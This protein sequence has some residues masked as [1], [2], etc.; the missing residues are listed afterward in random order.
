MKRSG[1][2]AVIFVCALALTGCPEPTS[3]DAG[4]PAPEAGTDAPL[5]ID[6]EVADAGVGSESGVDA[7]PPVSDSI[8][9]DWPLCPKSDKCIAVCGDGLLHWP[10]KCDG[11]KFGNKTCNDYGFTGGKLKCKNDC[12]VDTSKCYKCGDGKIDPNESCEGTNLQGKTCQSLGYKGGSLSCKKCQLY[13]W[14]CVPYGCGNGAIDNQE[15]CDGAKLGGKTCKDLGYK[16]GTLG[17]HVNCQYNTGSCVSKYCGNGK[18]DTGEECDDAIKVPSTGKTCKDFG[19]TGGALQCKNCKWYKWWCIPYGCGNGVLNSGEDCDGTNMSSQTCVTQGYYTG[20]LGCYSNC[21]FNKKGCTNCGNNKKDK[22]EKCDGTDLDSQTCKTR[23]FDWGPLTCKSD[24]SAFDTSKC[25]HCTCGDG[26]VGGPEDCD[27]TNLDGKDCTDLG[28]DGGTLACQSNCAF[29][30]TNCYGCGDGKV[31]GIEQCEGK[32]LNGKTCKDQG[33]HGG[34][35]ACDAK[36][37]FDTSGCTNCGNGT[38]N[39]TEE[40]DGTDLNSKACSG[41]GF[42]YGTLACK[43]DCTLDK[44]G[45]KKYKCGDGKV[46]GTEKCDGTNLDGKT[47]VS[48]GYYGGTLKCAKCAFDTS[49]CTNCGNGKLDSGEQC[50]GTGLGG[51]TCKTVGYHYGTLA[52]KS[53]CTFNKAGCKKYYCGDGKITGSEVCDGKLLNGKDC[54]SYGYFGGGLLCNSKCNGYNKAGCH[55]CGDWKINKGEQCDTGNLNGKNCNKLGYNYGVLSCKP[56]ACQYDTSKCKKWVCGNGKIEGVEECE[57]TNLNSQTCKS[58]GYAGGTLKCHTGCGFDFSLCYVCGDGKL[59]GIEQCEGTNL[60]GKTCK[61]LGYTAG[62][63]KCTKKCFYDKA[64]CYKCGDG[65]INP[66]EKCDKTNLGGKTCKSFGFHTGSLKCTSSCAFNTAGCHNCGDSK[67]QLGEQ[68]DKSNFNSK[69][70]VSYGF[71]GGTLGC[72][73]GCK[74]VLTK[75]HKCGDGKID[76]GEGCDGTNMGGHSCKSHG[77]YKGTMKCLPGCKLDESGCSTCGDGK[78]NKGEQCDGKDFHGKTCKSLG[79]TTGTLS[80]TADCKKVV[81]TACYTIKTVGDDIFADFSKGTL[82]GSGAKIYVSGKGNV[83]LQDRLDLNGDGRFDLVFSNWFNGVTS[84]VM[85]Y[86]YWG[87][88]SGFSSSNRASLPTVGAMGSSSADL[89]DDGHVDLVFSNS[90]EIKLKTNTYTYY[91]YKVNSYVYWGGGSGSYSTA[92]RTALPTLGAT[93]NT[94]ADLNR[95]GYLD[96]IFSNNYDGTTKK[97]NSFIYWGGPGGFSASKR[98]ELPTLGAAG[99]AVAD[100]NGDGY[101]DIVFSNYTDGTSVAVSSYIYWGSATGFSTAKRTS[102]PTSAATGCTAAD[103]N[104][105][106]HLDLVFSNQKNASTNKV[107]SYVYWGSAGGYSV[108]KRTS[109]PTQGASGNSVAD[110]NGDGHLDIVFSNYMDDTTTNVNSYVYWGSATGFSASKR[111]EL[112]TLGAGGNHVSDLNGDG[113]LDVAFANKNDAS[114]LAI[115]SYVYWGSATGPKASNRS[116]LATLGATWVSNS[117]DPGAVSD[118]GVKHQFLSRVFDTGVSSPVY[119]NISI[120]TVTPKNTTLKIQVRTAATAAGLTS[121]T[122]SGASGAGTYYTKS[123]S[124]ASAHNGDRY[125]QYRALMSSDLASTP[126]LDLL[127]VTYH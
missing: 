6:M 50:D 20:T 115:K 2:L 75:C 126:L 80:C 16:G 62:V 112:P 51:K 99:D 42:D 61:T 40:C 107:S 14:W 95:D 90:A 47:C 74:V 67:I 5:Q 106:G 109:L 92:N 87:A 4:T 121:A 108:A 48:Q 30:T 38:V 85:S 86:I 46:T 56:G 83:Q 21:K 89:N 34:A 64:G 111:A 110:L 17:C 101:L 117:A 29:D 114:S 88:K 84:S 116:E 39:G 124:L 68:C 100:L 23:G 91:N 79:F 81:T 77:Y 98:T 31:S 122:W 96:I 18:M 57:G 113:Y 63:L 35:L 22:G 19:Y 59:N 15:K 43:K 120:K 24:C 53:D 66:G 37:T 76:P 55:N 10:E 36:C 33:F 78:W 127:K 3:D 13:S 97:I 27:K 41:V 11:T 9:P 104:G 70:C 94:I 119:H 7:L 60:G 65:T 44:T 32:D 123:T 49:G 82:S 73:S 69:T 52:C 28:Y 25:E 118:R 26:I 105:D 12:T 125:I 102:L 103:L 1:L 93:D 58:Q 71:H 72:T 54:V 8:P 45:C